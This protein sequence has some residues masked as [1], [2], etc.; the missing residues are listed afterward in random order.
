M[1]NIPEMMPP[2]EAVGVGHT[3][4][5]HVTGDYVSLKDVNMAFIVCHVLQGN[6]AI[7]YFEP[8]Q[9]T[10]VAG[11]SAKALTN[12]CGIWSCLDC[13]AGDAMTKRTDAKSYNLDAGVKHK[14]VVFQI[15]PASLDIAN[16]FD[17][18]SIYADTSNA[19][20]LLAAQYYLVRRNAEDAPASAISD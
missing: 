11:T 8:K 13:A 12:N 16:G 9:A 18:L 10:A 5:A 2:I 4:D 7:T 3:L 14:I 1:I 15:D 19:A 6:A 20:N 17:C